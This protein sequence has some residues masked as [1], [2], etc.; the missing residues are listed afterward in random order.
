MNI[1]ILFLFA[2]C[3]VTDNIQ[4]NGTKMIILLFLAKTMCITLHNKSHL[5]F[6]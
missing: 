6:I 5:T 3:W 4:I 2:I 1:Y